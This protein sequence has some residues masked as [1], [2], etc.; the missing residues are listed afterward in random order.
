MKEILLEILKELKKIN[1]HLE[2]LTRE[3]FKTGRR[4]DFLP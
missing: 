1:A 3:K 2:M 4:F